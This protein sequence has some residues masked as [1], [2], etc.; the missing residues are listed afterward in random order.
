MEHIIGVISDTHGMFDP[1][2]PPLFR[3]CDHILHA[4]DV[5]TRQVLEQLSRLAPLTAISGNVDQGILFPDLESE[6]M[7]NLYGIPIFL[8]HILGDPLRLKSPIRQKISSLQPAVVVFGHSHKPFLERIG[9]VLFFNPGS[10][11]PKRFSL[12]RGAGILRISG[13][14]CLGEWM[15]LD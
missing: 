7:V 15:A 13:K 11:G 1:G 2:I 14:D 3:N 5:G 4:G 6:K 12:P 9:E 8:I 10:A